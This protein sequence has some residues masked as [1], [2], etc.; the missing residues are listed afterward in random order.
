MEEWNHP[1]C[2]SLP[3]RY[4]SAGEPR[5]GAGSRTAACETPESNQTSSM[6]ISF[7]KLLF[8]HFGQ[9]VPAGRSR[10]ALQSYQM[11]ALCSL[12]SSA[13]W[14]MIGASARYSPHSVQEKAVM[15]TPHDLWREMHQSG[16]F[17]I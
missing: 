2:W 12:N 3:S 14:N 13:T 1:R 4:M 15:G 16:R 10:S 9:T 17:S 5:L 11:S 6:S 8:P 7:S